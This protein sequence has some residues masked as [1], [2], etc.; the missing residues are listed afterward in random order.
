MPLAAQVS[1]RPAVQPAVKAAVQVTVQAAPAPAAAAPVPADATPMAQAQAQA[2]ALATQAATVLAPPGARVLVQAG[3]LDHRLQLAP[4]T[5]IEPYLPTGVPSWGRTRVGLRCTEGSR[6]WNV[7]LPLTVQ[8]WAPAVVAKSTLPAGT[9]LAI[10]Q[11][12]L[13]EQD[14]AAGPQAPLADVQALAGRTLA[15]AVTNGQAVR[16]VDLQSRQWFAAGETVRV[17]TVGGGF[18]VTAEG[19]ALAAGVEGRTVRVMIGEDRV[20]LG[21]AVGEHRVE[22]SL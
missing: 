2:L 13:V 8:V 11:L 17:V 16:D 6:R 4:C 1:V 9:R 14:W 21:R 22:V 20:V 15:R 19:R 3:A 12:A 10:E 7:S 5:R 18:S